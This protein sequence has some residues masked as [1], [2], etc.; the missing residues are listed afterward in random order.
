MELVEKT[1]NQKAVI[2]ASSEARMQEAVSYIMGRI[3]ET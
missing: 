2:L 3:M 1:K